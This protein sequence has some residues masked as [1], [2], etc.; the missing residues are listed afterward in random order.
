[1]RYEVGQKVRVH[2]K[3]CG[4]PAEV[5]TSYQQIMENGGIA[6]IHEVRSG[7]RLALYVEPNGI[8]ANYYFKDVTQFNE[9]LEGVEEL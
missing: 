5:S 4:I 6:T 3:T 7:D 9:T 8:K 2:G 1:M